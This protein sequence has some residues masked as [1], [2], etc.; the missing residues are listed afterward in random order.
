MNHECGDTEHD[1]N[2][3]TQLTKHT[4]PPPVT[5]KPLKDPVCGMP[6][7]NKSWIR[8]RMKASLTTFA[9]HTAKTGSVQNRVDSLPRKQRFNKNG[10]PPATD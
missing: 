9:A 1:M 4:H 6:V 10:R 2:D 8:I 3:D 5:S 7:T